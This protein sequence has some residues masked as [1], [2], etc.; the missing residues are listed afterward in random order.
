MTIKEAYTILFF[1]QAYQ[2]MMSTEKTTR[3]SAIVKNERA[4]AVF[5]DLLAN[6]K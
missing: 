3:K 6:S 2:E 1:K 4:R 5:A